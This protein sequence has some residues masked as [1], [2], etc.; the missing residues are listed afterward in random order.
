MIDALYNGISG[1]SIYQKALNTESNNIANV[2]TLA[3]KSDRVSF[4]DMMYQNGYGKGGQALSVEKDFAQGN[5]KITNNTYDMAIVGNGYFTVQDD[6]NGTFYTRAGNFRMASDGSLETPTGLDVMGVAMDAPTVVGTNA[7]V[8]VFNS[9]YTNF[10]STQTISSDTLISTIN[11]KATDYQ[12]AAT[13]SGVS[14]SGYKTAQSKISDAEVLATEYRSQ[15]SL[16]ANNTI[17]GTASTAQ[18]STTTFPPASIND[19]TDKISIYVGGNKYT[20]SFE[21]DAKTTLN[22]FADQLATIKG[23]TSSVDTVTGELTITSLIP[24]KDILVS[25]AALNGIAVNID[26]TDATKGTGLASV[27]SV[28]DALKRS[29]EAA[30][31]EFLEI[32]SNIT[33]NN[34]N[35][36]TLNTIQLKLDN[37]NLSDSP[38]GTM[39]VDN[40]IIYM[41]QGDNKF[42]VG[43]VIISEFTD[44]LALKPQGNNLYSKTKLSGEPILIDEANKIQ[45]NTLELSNSDLSEGLVNLMVYQRSFEANSKSIT[46]SDEFLKTAIQL[47]K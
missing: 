1:L 47:K 21:T 8:S 20:Q 13:A 40:G 29:I 12:S 42:V 2:N 37:L 30:G 34:E 26:T 16:Y 35:N 17:E 9:G 7:N 3:Y 43:K 10:L 32:T 15:L 46:T 18:V 5:M 38:F 41:K 6:A 44:N 4:A 22:S 33:L 39:S 25:G 11:A 19:S 14:G 28:R 23:F 31:G 45:N 27:N 36:L 24:G